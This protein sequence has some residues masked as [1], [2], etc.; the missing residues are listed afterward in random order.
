MHIDHIA[1][2]SSFI[3]ICLF[4]FIVTKIISKF[5]NNNILQIEN[6]RIEI[7]NKI[8][9]LEKKL[10]TAK[11]LLSEKNKKS[12]D[13]I[14]KTRKKADEFLKTELSKMDEYYVN[15]KKDIDTLMTNLKQDEIKTIQKELI[16]ESLSEVESKNTISFTNKSDNK[17]I[18]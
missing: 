8:E 16:S 4:G 5:L 18:N 10:K 2:F 14:K 15:R 9:N 7:D 6:D 1:H 3:G 17:I 12:I 11:D 13:E